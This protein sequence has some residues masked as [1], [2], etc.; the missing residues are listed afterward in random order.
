MHQQLNAGGKIF[1]R[2]IVWRI[3]W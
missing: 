1:I 3:S 2:E